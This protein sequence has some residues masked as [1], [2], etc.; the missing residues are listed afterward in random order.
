MKTIFH[1]GKRTIRS[2]FRIAGVLLAILVISMVSFVST[3]DVN[4]HKAEII[5]AVNQ[6]TGRQ[7][8][9]EGDLSLSLR[10]VPTIKAENVS[11]SNAAWGT[12]PT[13]V[14]TKEI[15][16]QVALIPLINGQIQIE[17]LWL[18]EPH[19]RLE[20][21]QRGKGN[22]DLAEAAPP[23]DSDSTIISINQVDIEQALIEMYD[24]R[25]MQTQRFE[26]EQLSTRT[27][28]DNKLAVS[29]KA[30]YENMPFK[31]DGNLGSPEV[32]LANQSFPIDVAINSDI[33]NFKVSGHIK[34]PL[35][36]VQPELDI[37]G[38]LADITALNRF[39]KAE[40]PDIGSA[41]FIGKF[42]LQ[43]NIVTIDSL[44]LE[45][46]NS[47]LTGSV[48]ANISAKIPTFTANLAADHL[49]LSPL[50][51]QTEPDA[52]AA[53]S[54]QLFS[55]EPLPMAMLHDIDAD[56]A[57]VAKQVHTHQQDFSDVDIKA[58]L[59]QGKLK[60]DISKVGVLGGV[61]SGKF[62]VDDSVKP[63]KVASKLALNGLD[64][65][66]IP[67][68][69]SHLTGALSNINM[70]IA[71]QGNSLHRLASVANGSVL[72][73]VGEGKVDM[74]KAHLFGGDLLSMLNPMKESGGDTQLSCAVVNLKISDGMA[75]TDKG[76][77]VETP[78]MTV[79]GSGN[80]DLNSEQLDIGLKTHAREGL[81]V[82]VS[83]L[84]S[85][86]RIGGTLANPE[87]TTD[88]SSA[89]G[90][91]LKVQSAIVTGG[92]S[93]LAQGLF[94]RVT[95]DKNPC[96]TAVKMPELEKGKPKK[97]GITDAID[98]LFD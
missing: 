85:F 15:E 95:A 14:S 89:V 12:A 96:E 91:G 31:L 79:V 27:V 97:G 63:T 35:T 17:K 54:E 26:I 90:T 77:A 60:L 33:G 84:A 44:Q 56:V 25:T 78:Q 34:Q 92:L 51:P 45:A 22:W 66:Q 9:I 81:G 10:L 30:S 48:T 68:L 1:I 73:Q 21:N 65:S 86:I 55:D 59:K 41:N 74:K 94:D 43:D 72:V 6:A 16:L 83:N 5:S 2:S 40:L 39:V 29:L 24:Q 20:T 53:D 71:T 47:Q 28:D 70:Q 80:I 52:K 87:P 64:P 82:S 36:A 88:L 42:Q 38:S 67:S 11:F 58:S 18:S 62:S 8:S 69:N 57:L 98:S 7:L 13:M 19:I 61:L 50:P 3:F 75:Y 46:G 93:L 23:S 4:Q 32:L 37:S 76:I 49:D